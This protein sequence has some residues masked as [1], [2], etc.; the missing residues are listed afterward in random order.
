MWRGQNWRRRSECYDSDNITYA[1][2]FCSSTDFARICATLMVGC[3]MVAQALSRWLRFAVY[4]EVVCILFCL[5]GG[6]W[7]GGG[8]IFPCHSC[9][10]QTRPDGHRDHFF[11]TKR[12]R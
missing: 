4:C 10:K 11:K 7:W 2:R 8:G 1:M 12:A 5:M 6:W 9:A 3:A